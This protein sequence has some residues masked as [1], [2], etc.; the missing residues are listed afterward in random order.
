M[1]ERIFIFVGSSTRRK[2]KKRYARDIGLE[3]KLF[4]YEKAKM[5]IHFI[6]DRH[7]MKN[8]ILKNVI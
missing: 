7:R 4:L 6:S 3:I 1:M 2:I 5:E 8:A